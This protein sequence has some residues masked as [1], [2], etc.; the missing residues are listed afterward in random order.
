MMKVALATCASV[1]DL[2]EDDR[3]LLDELS[4]RGITA[5]PVVWNDLGVRWSTFDRVVIRSCW[6]YHLRLPQFLAWLDHVEADKVPLWNPAPLVRSN[7]HKSYL[8]ELKAAGLPV[9][10]TAWLE[11][12]ST[13][14]LGRLLQDRGWSE[15]VIK[16][17]VSAS[18]FRTWRVSAQ[19]AASGDTRR[20]FR[21]LVA[22]SDVLV[23]PFLREIEQEGEWSFVFLGGE[24]SHAVLKRPAAGDFR[25]QAEYGGSVLTQPPPSS[26][27]SEA[28][29]VAN[30]L[31]GPWAYA[32]IDAVLAEGALTLM[33][34]ELIEPYLFLG[35]H[36][37]AAVRLADAILMPSSGEPGA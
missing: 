17:A 15:A 25:V 20:A 8:K 22:E 14:D 10:P 19:D 24:F 29:A 11:R 3:L 35:S 13:L 28:K 26:A 23:Q 9:V 2:T 1:P 33:E 18:A 30:H 27:I 36:P 6:D 21:E 37:M 4:R 34:V 7:A 31:R 32:R 5:R 12:G 16:P